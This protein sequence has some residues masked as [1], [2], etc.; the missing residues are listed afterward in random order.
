MK[1]NALLCA[2]SRRPQHFPFACSPA[3]Q[4]L[5]P[6]G[7][8]WTLI[9]PPVRPGTRSS[10]TAVRSSVLHYSHI[11][12]RA[13]PGH[14][15]GT[16]AGGALFPLEISDKIPALPPPSLCSPSQDM[17]VGLRELHGGRGLGAPEA[18][19]GHWKPRPHG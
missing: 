13:A 1:T 6:R 15:A 16:G 19:R 5:Q 3:R 12:S 17:G 10:G 2:H 14:V 4:K 11:P 8:P 18:A 7:I 9:T